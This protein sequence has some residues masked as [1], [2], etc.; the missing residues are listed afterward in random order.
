MFRLKLIL[1]II[2]ITSLA[3]VSQ[4]G[5]V[6][7]RIFNETNNEPV[8]FAN[9]IIYGTT[10]G[11]SSDLDG[12]FLFTGIEPGFIQLAV[13]AVGF[14]QKVT[15]DFQVTNAKTAYIDVALLE[16]QLELQEVVITASPFIRLDESPVSV[17]SLLLSR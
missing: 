11:T 8:P 12:N 14:E 5:T 13:S 16:K 4:E 7:G 9:I 1:I 3:A 10:I 15:E 2:L 17:Q 6:K